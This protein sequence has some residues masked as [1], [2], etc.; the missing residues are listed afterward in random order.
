M[1]IIL[2]VATLTPTFSEIQ[3]DNVE[4]SICTGIR[5]LRRFSRSVKEFAWH[6][7]TLERLD[8]ARKQRMI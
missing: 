3:P 2:M 4:E 8:L 1:T 7:Q 6:V 5:N